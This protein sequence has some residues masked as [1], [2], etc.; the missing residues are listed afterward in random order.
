MVSTG[1]IEAWH[2]LPLGVAAGAA[3]AFAAPATRA[4]VVDLVGRQRALTGNGLNEVAGSAGEIL[5]PAMAGFL[6]A[7]TDVAVVYYLAGAIYVASVMLTLRM[8]HGTQQSP[9]PKRSI[10]L[11]DVRDGLAYARSTP[12]IPAML[13]SPVPL[14]SLWRSFLCSRSTPAMSSTLGPPVSG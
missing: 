5:G 11:Y 3:W 7:W 8:R 9:R 6:I 10:L 4:I 13:V 2:L 12:G 14:S 1:L